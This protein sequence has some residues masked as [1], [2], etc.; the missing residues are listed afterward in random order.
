MRVNPLTIGP[1]VGATT[2]TEVHLWGRGEFEK[3]QLGCKRCLGIARIKKLDDSDF[4]TGQF[5][6]LN[7]NF[8]MTG[9]TI[10]NNLAPETRYIF[11]IGWFFSEQSYSETP[12]NLRINWTQASTGE[13]KT[14]SAD[15]QAPRQFIFG[16]CRYLLRLFLG[17]L[18]DTRGDKTFQTISKLLGENHAINQFLMLGDQIYADDLNVIGADTRLDEYYKRY[19]QAFSQPYI[20]QVMSQIPTYMTLDDHEIEDNWPAQST[21]KDYVTKYPAA[22]HAYLTYQASHSPLF[23]AHEKRITGIPDRLWYTFSDGCCDYFM[24]DTRTE[25]HLATQRMMS[26][27]QMEALKCWLKDGSNRVKIIA[28]SVLLFPDAVQGNDD[29]WSGFP[30]QRRELFDWIFHHKIKRVVCI[31]GDIHA[32]LSAELVSPDEP[33]FKIICVV[34]SPFFWPYPHPTSNAFKLEGTLEKSALATYNM[35]NASEP[36]RSDNFTLVKVDLD[37]VEVNVFPRKA[38]QLKPIRTKVHSFT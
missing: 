12:D 14:A 7:P 32:S 28:T 19:R 3:T 16:S 9:V 15:L 21:P 18:F 8:D 13:V 33:E 26:D 31:S 1:I 29:Q 27:E 37:K 10:F 23:P 6:K 17:S 36:Y 24:T 4:G 2:T 20:R 30:E 25:R 34:S 35:A 38:E 22:I 11:Q 5:F